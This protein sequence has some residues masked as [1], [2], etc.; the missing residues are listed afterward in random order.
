MQSHEKIAFLDLEISYKNAGGSLGHNILV[1]DF[2][3][4]LKEFDFDE[5]KN[6]KNQVIVSTIH[7]AKGKEFDFVFVGFDGNFNLHRGDESR[8]AY[9]AFTRAKQKLFI[10]S[11]KSDLLILKEHFNEFKI[12]DKKDEAPPT[13][14][15]IMGLND[16]Y[17]DKT[18]I[19][20]LKTNIVAGDE[21]MLKIQN[22]ADIKVIDILWENKSIASLSNKFVSLLFEKIKQG[23]TLLEKAKVQYVVKWYNKKKDETTTQILCEI[24][25]TR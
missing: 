2:E 5:L 25:L 15:Y 4:F 17:L 10:H 12:Y 8:L 18:N 20:N 16:I 11:Q 13:I 7:K 3:L 1:A 22:H 19:K 9:V 14:S 23:Y 21:C 24:C 6:F